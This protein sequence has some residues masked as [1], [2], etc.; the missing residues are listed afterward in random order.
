VSAISPVLIAGAGLAGLAVAMELSRLGV[1]VRLIGEPPGPSA[2]SRTLVVHSLTSVLLEQRGLSPEALPA[3][4]PVRH[5]AVYTKGGLLGVA[6]L[7]PDS[8]HRRYALLA[9]RV[10]RAA[11]ASR[12]C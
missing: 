3:S 5:T 8:D 1:P 2:V 7:A 12:R 6:E 10:S 4:N 9:G 11:P